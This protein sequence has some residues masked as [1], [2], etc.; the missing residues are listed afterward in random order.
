MTMTEPYCLHSMRYPI[1]AV[2][3]NRPPFNVSDDVYRVAISLCGSAEIVRPPIPT[4][5]APVSG[6]AV[7]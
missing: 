6:F 1:T 5:Q 4:S 7:V 2:G 3:V